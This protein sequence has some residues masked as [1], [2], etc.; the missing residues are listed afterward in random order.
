MAGRAR[1]GL[2]LPRRCCRLSS[3]VLPVVL[4]LVVAL[5]LTGL[6]SDGT[7]LSP[8]SS[9]PLPPGAEARPE[10]NITLPSI[11]ANTTG[12]AVTT[13]D[14]AVAGNRGLRVMAPIPQLPANLSSNATLVL[15]LGEPINSSVSVFIGF[16][17]GEAF[18]LSAAVPFSYVNDSGT[19]TV[20]TGPYLLPPGA[21]LHTFSFQ[22]M[23][24]PWWTFTVDGNLLTGGPDSQG[25]GTYDLGSTSASAFAATLPPAPSLAFG[26]TGNHS[27]APS[28][29][30]PEAL[31][32]LGAGGWV[33]TTSAD[34]VLDQ[35]VGLAGYLQ[36]PTI[37]PGALEVAPGLPSLP[38]LT[39][40]WDTGAL[41][42]LSL[43]VTKLPF[44]VPAGT[45]LTLRAWANATGGTGVAANLNVTD[46]L[47][48]SVTASPGGTVGTFLIKF[49]TPGV[50]A[51]TSDT[52]TLRATAPGFVGAVRQALT[53]ITPSNLSLVGPLGAQSVLSNG[54]LLLS[55]SLVNAQ[56]GAWTASVANV[57]LLPSQGTAQVLSPATAPPGTIQVLYHA[58]MVEAPVPVDLTLS[59]V[60]FGF[61]PVN[62]TTPITVLPR[63]LAIAVPPLPT[64]SPGQNFTLRLEVSGPGLGPGPLD[65]GTWTVSGGRPTPGGV[66]LGPFEGLGYG[67]VSVP[68]HVSSNFTGNLTLQLGLTVPGYTP[69]LASL[70]IGIM[71]N[72]TLVVEDPPL[73]LAAGSQGIVH[74]QV[75][76]PFPVAD[77]ILVLT[78]TEGTW[79]GGAGSTLRVPVPANGSVWAVLQA[80]LDLVTGSSTVRV[81]LEAMGF[82][83]AGAEWVITVHPSW[84]SFFGQ[85]WAYPLVVG[86]GLA[87]ALLA[88]WVARRRQSGN[89]PPGPAAGTEDGHDEAPG[90]TG[91]SQA[92]EYSEGG[93]EGPPPGP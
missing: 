79:V 27:P 68:L 60:A 62:A 21:A 24:G 81:T 40:L 59:A 77:G 44:S 78:T 5:L 55:Y 73:N 32:Y 31:S 19:V 38:P 74:V 83:P 41:P 90:A 4:A 6:L 88:V 93:E 75:L 49:Q 72:A 17:E 87:L 18:G 86:V 53:N 80:P 10:A 37:P 51:P 63:P 84:Q 12:F 42:G 2:G 1:R 35:G 43:N 26:V 14:L 36:D 33:N 89:P 69:A 91:A 61:S 85:A 3:L 82:H 16:A 29:S 70:S 23:H 65:N 58:P 56:G 54:T 15:A 22:E 13:T 34:S 11:G 30:L 47:G 45:D 28:L 76:T 66:T 52:L 7:A 64:L 48:T 9:L 8:S 20:G 71:A 25:N 39:A 92:P 46:A 67:N 57:T 50:S